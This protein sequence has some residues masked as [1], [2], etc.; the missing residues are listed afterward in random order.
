MR[1][2][3]SKLRAAGIHTGFSLLI[4]S[5]VL[6]LILKVWYPYPLWTI[7][8]GDHLFFLVLGIDIILGPLITFIVFNPLKSRL[9]LRIDIAVVIFLQLLALSYG[10]HAITSSRPIH[11]VFEYD[12]F[13]VVHANE[14][15]ADALARSRFP[16]VPWSGPTWVGVRGLTANEKFDYTLAAIGGVPVATRPELWT[17]LSEAAPAIL[18]AAKPIAEL[19]TRSGNV[20]SAVNA[21]L[22]ALK[23]TQ[24]EVRYLPLQGRSQNAATVLLDASTGKPLGFLS[25]DSF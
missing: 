18:S 2:L 8:G 1:G 16:E 11:Y 17:A 3:K 23:K 4:G 5:C 7:S 10:L 24:D 14:V 6:L 19:S 22:K 13:R 15:P 21:K 12:R 20:A 25:I 9:E